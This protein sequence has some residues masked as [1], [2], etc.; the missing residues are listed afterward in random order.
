MFG[1]NIVLYYVCGKN[2]TRG[3]LNSLD[4]QPNC[5]THVWVAFMGEKEPQ[6]RQLFCR[7]QQQYRRRLFS[8]RRWFKIFNVIG[9]TITAGG[10][11]RLNTLN[12]A[13]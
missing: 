7:R 13:F 9:A 3:R 8:Q 10:Y 12:P 5:N 2:Q 11:E 6:Q 4:F 1:N